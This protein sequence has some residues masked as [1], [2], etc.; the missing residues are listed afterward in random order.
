MVHA[1]RLIGAFFA[2]GSAYW[3]CLMDRSFAI[4]NAAK[5]P[6]DGKEHCC[7]TLLLGI[8]LMVVYLPLGII[9]KLAKRYY[10]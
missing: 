7:M 9:F 8:F 6:E 5:P 4:L 1:M 3:A 2:P 10:S